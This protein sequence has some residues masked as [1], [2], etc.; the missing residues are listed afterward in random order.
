MGKKRVRKTKRYTKKR[1]GGDTNTNT[2]TI[3][4]S[5]KYTSG[6]NHTIE[7]LYPTNIN[8]ETYILIKNQD[9]D[10]YNEFPFYVDIQTIEVQMNNNSL[11]DH[12]TIS[13]QTV[14]LNINIKHYSKTKYINLFFYIYQN[15]T[16]TANLYFSV[17]KLLYNDGIFASFTNI[18]FYK[19]VKDGISWNNN[20]LLI[21]NN[22]YTLNTDTNVDPFYTP[23][24]P[25]IFLNQDMYEPV[26][27]GPEYIMLRDWRMG[28]KADMHNKELVFN[29]FT[30][31]A[32]SIS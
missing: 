5:E 21:K 14:I 2:N 16:K 11:Q 4:Y 13:T 26:T 9:Y 6:E 29:V 30:R 8:K 15:D 32:C 20:T 1:K 28:E 19:I 7:I 18:L 22:V 25:S 12:P 24:K 27:S 23:T 10:S 17:R 3:N 31:F